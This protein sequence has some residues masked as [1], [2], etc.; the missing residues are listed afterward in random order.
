MQGAL[1][2]QRARAAIMLASDGPM[3]AEVIQMHNSGTYNN[4]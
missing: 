3:F 4:Q 2:W 1:S